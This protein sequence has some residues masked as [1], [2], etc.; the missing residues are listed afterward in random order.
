M[1]YSILHNKH[2][3]I[4]CLERNPYLNLYSIGDLDDFFRPYT[5]WYGI[6]SGNH[7]KE[8]VLVYNGPQLPTIVGL[9]KNLDNMKD[10]LESIQDLLPPRFYAHL[11]PG[12]ESL[13]RREFEVETGIPHY[14]MA[15]LNKDILPGINTDMVSCLS[16]KD[17][18]ALRALYD[19]SYPENWFDPRMLMTNQYFGIREDNRIIAAAGVH[20]FSLEYKA[21][22]I[23]NIVTDSAYRKMG[24]GTKV[25][26]ALCK[27]L[28]SANLRVGLNV[29]TDNKAAAECYRKLGFEINA[30]YEE[31]IIS[32]KV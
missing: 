13:F 24:Y 14:K 30:A 10:L 11:S 18:P 25:T 15:L 32:R 23:G 6:R 20:V 4:S 3:I 17:L 31:Y 21:A 8:I 27:S 19:K 7:V 22:A 12:L 26:A 29:R 9:S 16:D 28:L 5:T 2:E 1:S